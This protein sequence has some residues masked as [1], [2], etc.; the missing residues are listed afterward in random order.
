MVV[1]EKSI[2]QIGTLISLF[3]KK[4]DQKMSRKQV[5]IVRG[6]FEKRSLDNKILEADFRFLSSRLGYHARMKFNIESDWDGSGKKWWTLEEC[7]SV[8]WKIDQETT[9]FWSVSHESFFESKSIIHMNLYMIR[10]LDI[11]QFVHKIGKEG[12][13]STEFHEQ[14]SIPL[15]T[16][17]GEPTLE[18]SGNNHLR[19]LIF[20][21][22]K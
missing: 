13:S 19:N 16:N 8:D 21:G 20:K 18:L 7:S 3:P 12:V 5:I 15:L 9:R 22:T 4:A 2:I 6:Y 1:V 14:F 11:E 17:V 10:S